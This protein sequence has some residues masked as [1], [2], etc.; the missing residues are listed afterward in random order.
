MP[1]AFFEARHHPAGLRF[2]RVLALQKQGD[3]VG[4]DF[5][6]GQKRVGGVAGMKK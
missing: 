5:L 6:F 3:Q 1:R 4:V 2:D